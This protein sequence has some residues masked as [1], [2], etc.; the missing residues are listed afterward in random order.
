MVPIQTEML[1]L[2][3]TRT[4]SNDGKVQR[5]HKTAISGE[6]PG[7]IIPSDDNCR[8]RKCVPVLFEA[9][10]LDFLLRA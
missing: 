5:C 8:Q 1:D 6:Y 9:V 10:A 3:S 2:S 7:E 4:C